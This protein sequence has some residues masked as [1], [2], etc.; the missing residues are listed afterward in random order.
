MNFAGR[1]RGDFNEKV[2]SAFAFGDDNDDGDNMDLDI[3]TLCQV[4][5]FVQVCEFSLNSTLFT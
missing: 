5:I 1:L 4:I 2:K 3:G